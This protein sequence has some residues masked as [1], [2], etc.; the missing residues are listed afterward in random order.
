[1]FSICL[2]VI[3]LCLSVLRCTFLISLFWI[4]TVSF[5]FQ[6]KVSDIY[7]IAVRVSRTTWHLDE[8]YAIVAF[9]LMKMTN[10]MAR[11]GMTPDL[12]IHPEHTTEFLGSQYFLRFFCS[13]LVVFFSCFPFSSSLVTW[14]GSSP[15]HT[16]SWDSDFSLSCQVFSS[17]CN[18]FFYH[19]DLV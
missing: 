17:H 6:G 4:G 7:T 14:K 15:K 11:I 9:L 13:F 10:M 3:F 18:Y 5:W 1:M 12:I 19:F 16:V 8:I 2:G